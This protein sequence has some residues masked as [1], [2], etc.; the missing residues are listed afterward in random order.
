MSEDSE[1]TVGAAL[2]E[3]HAALFGKQWAAWIGGLLLAVINILLFAYEK[4]WS[5]ADG[6][7]GYS[8]P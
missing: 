1:K 7:T 2:S 6:V 3:G 8:T 5:A 4:P